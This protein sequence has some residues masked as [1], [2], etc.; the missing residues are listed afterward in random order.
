M[1]MIF[2]GPETVRVKSLRIYNRWGAMVHEQYD[3]PPNDP[4]FGWDGFHKGAMQNSAVYVY[5]AEVIFLDGS[6][7]AFKGEFT[8]VR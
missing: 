8:L 7:A 3:F 2:S 1:F 6:E 5:R 4:A